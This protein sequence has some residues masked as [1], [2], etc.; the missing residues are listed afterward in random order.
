MPPTSGSVSVN[1]A[2]PVPLGLLYRLKV[3]VPVGLKPPVTV[4]LS[5]MAVPTGALAGC[6]VVV[7][8]GVGKLTTTGSAA[9]SL[10]AKGSGLGMLVRG[11][12]TPLKVATQ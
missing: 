11:L 5:A 9:G 3:T 2:G 10:L 1:S 7:M 12:W 8:A 4:A 6:W